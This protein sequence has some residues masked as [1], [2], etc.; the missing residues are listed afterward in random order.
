MK[1][2]QEKTD[3]IRLPREGSVY[4]PTAF[5]SQTKNVRPDEDPEPPSDTFD[6]LPDGIY[7]RFSD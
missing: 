5:H 3:G 7:D 4:P 1:P 6:Y 2:K